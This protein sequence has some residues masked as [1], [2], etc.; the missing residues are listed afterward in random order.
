MTRNTCRVFLLSHGG[1]GAEFMFSHF[2]TRTL[3]IYRIILLPHGWLDVCVQSSCYHTEGPE[4]MSS[5]LIVTWLRVILLSHGR[6]QVHVQSTCCYMKAL[7]KCRVILLSHG[8]PQ[9]SSV[10]L[11][12]HVESFCYHMNGS[13]FMISRLIV[14]WRVLT[15]C[16]VILL[17]DGWLRVHVQWSF[18]YMEGPGL[19]FILLLFFF[20]AAENT[21]WLFE[22]RVGSYLYV[23][24]RGPLATVF[25]FS[26]FIFSWCL[27]VAVAAAFEYPEM[28]I[29]ILILIITIIIY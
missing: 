6:P 8:G 25:L 16:R 27:M 22:T 15:P 18:C 28:L 20:L 12:L 10:V 13:E 17:S 5:H 1:P 19:F 23:S 2:I 4:F 7:I 29:L 9:F 21:S 24:T 14:R 11:F 26:L 3:I